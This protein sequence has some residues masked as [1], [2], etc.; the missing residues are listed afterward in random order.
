MPK[1]K[2]ALSTQQVAALT[3]AGTYRVDN[4]LYLQVRDH[5][6]R[7][8]LFRYARHG[9]THWVGLGALR[10][11]PLSRAKQ[12][13]VMER[14]KLINGISPIEERRA[15]RE[16]ARA[17]APKQ[18]PTFAWCADQY[19]EAHRDGWRSAKH[20]EQWETTLR[21]YAGPIIGKLQVDKVS[22]EA[23]LG[24]LRPI[25]L[26]KPETATRPCGR[27]EKVL[28]W[29]TAKKY[30]SGENP[31]RWQGGALSHLLPAISKVQKIEHHKAI[32][33]SEIPALMWELSQ[34]DTAGAKALRF[35]IHTACRT[36]EVIGARWSE[37]DIDTATW[38][39]PADRMK[40][41][42]QHVVPLADEAVAILEALPRT[43]EFVFAGAKGKPLSNMTMIK[44]LRSLRD[45]EPTVHGTARASFST[46]AREQTDYPT[47]VIEAALA[48]KQ[49]DK[50]VAAYARTTYFDRRRD[51]MADWALY[52]MGTKAD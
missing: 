25:W 1:L 15:A 27:I 48:H 45:G 10:D 23:I 20:L 2:R 47:E 37:M 12:L 22:V 40:N 11:V 35:T 29:A 24:V 4:S 5:G 49:S 7:S 17:A 3:S 32:P 31:A 33:Y 16:M 43:S 18:V 52:C 19:I 51:L 13:A 26:T 41:G 30:R 9:K 28:G 6:T 46:W 50:V 36:G 21:T 8:W 14:A 44:C 39:I 42:Q 38:T 34:M